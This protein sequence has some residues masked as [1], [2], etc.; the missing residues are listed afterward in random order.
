MAGGFWTGKC[1]FKTVPSSP[2]VLLEQG[3]SRSMH[4][5]NKFDL[6]SSWVWGWERQV[7]RTLGYSQGTRVCHFAAVWLWSS[8]YHC[9]ITLWNAD[10]KNDPVYWL[11]WETRMRS[12]KQIH[13]W[14][15]FLQLTPLVPWPGVIP[16]Y[17]S[18]FTQ[19]DVLPAGAQGTETALLPASQFLDMYYELGIL[20]TCTYYHI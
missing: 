9:S 5:V 1:T 12:Y 10:D 2:K 19:L 8:L 6:P 4:P 16:K 18:D 13:I 17:L 7:E 3:W 11:G 14:T 20:G 15:G